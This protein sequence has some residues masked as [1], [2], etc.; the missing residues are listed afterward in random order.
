MAVIPDLSLVK[1]IASTW[2]LEVK[3]CHLASVLPGSYQ[4]VIAPT[5]THPGLHSRGTAK[6]FCA[7][8]NLSPAP[9]CSLKPWQVKGPEVPRRNI[10]L[11]ELLDFYTPQGH[12]CFSSWPLLYIIHPRTAGDSRHAHSVCYCIERLK[13]VFV[14][15]L[16]DF[17]L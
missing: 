15:H 13:N 17:N 8:G 12:I 5:A 14:Y 2:L 3:C 16:N 10:I 4:S 7:V 1:I 11:Q 9:A 6:P